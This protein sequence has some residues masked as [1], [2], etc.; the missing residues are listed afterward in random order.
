MKNAFGTPDHR[1][2]TLPSA[3]GFAPALEGLRAV[4]AF[5]VLTTHV[6]FQTGSSTGSFVHR[7]W[8]RFDLSVAVFFALSGFLL[9]RAHALHARLGEPGTARP[10]REYLRSRLVRIMPAYLVVAGAVFLLIPQNARASVATWT[11]NLTLTQVFVPDSLVEGLTHAWS[12]SVE[13]SFYLVLPLLWWALVR[14]RGGRARWRIPAIAAVGVAS[15]G[16]ALV[17]WYEL[18]LPERVNDQILPPAFASWF[19]AG[20]IL[21]ELAAAPPGRVAA[22]ARHARARWAWWAVAAAAFVATT[23]PEWFTEGF[24]HPSGPEFAARTGLGAVVAFCLLAPVALSPDRERFAVLGSAVMTT[25]GRWSYG[26]FLWH[27]LVLH[28]AFQIAAV[29][30]FSGRMLTIWLVTAVISTVVA[31]VGYALV[32]VPSQRWLAPRRAPRGRPADGQLAASPAQTSPA[33]VAT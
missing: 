3:T 31:A 21:A 22:L 1:V 27:V 26:V 14:L 15:L 9:W 7:V 29:P 16:W 32:E 23:V 12:L 24:V 4:A 18:G 11:S 13:M 5:A 33:T 17:P 2:G 30:M 28:F 8:G 6:A 20:M 25:V 10:A 19:A